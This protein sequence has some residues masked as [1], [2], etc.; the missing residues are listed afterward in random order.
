M[1]GT[2]LI[3]DD[4]KPT[5][6]GLRQSLEDDFD[7]YT[8]GNVEELELLWPMLFLY[9]RAMPVRADGAGRYRGGRG[10]ES[11]LDRRQ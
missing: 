10:F 4:E 3:V 9:R 11:S 1:R 7:V 6:E 8:A 5:R 2:I